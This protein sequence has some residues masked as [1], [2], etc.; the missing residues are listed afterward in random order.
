MIEFRYPGVY[1]VET[2][3]R[4]TPIDGV[5]TSGG[6]DRLQH[7]ATVSFAQ[8]SLAPTPEWTDANTGDPGVTL[9]ELLTYSL[10]AL[11]CRNAVATD[12]A[13][14]HGPSGVVDGLQIDAGRC[15]GVHVSAGLGVAADGT[16]VAG[17]PDPDPD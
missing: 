14:R 8:P 1:L 7:S 9:L 5:T 4:A 15:G 10:E 2:A 6:N 11:M 17:D 12:A 13:V 16:A 3:T